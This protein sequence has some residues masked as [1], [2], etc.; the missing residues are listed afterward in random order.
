MGEPITKTLLADAIESAVRSVDGLPQ[1][2]KI[3]RVQALVLNEP[4]IAQ[5]TAPIPRLRSE[6]LQGV[7][8]IGA[9]QLLNAF[10][11]TKTLVVA[12]GWFGKTW[13]ADEVST[14]L[15]T[16]VSLC[17]AAYAWY[18]RETASRPLA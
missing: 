3:A 5:A 12:V 2:E 9:T 14:V 17:L 15:I 11:V 6:V 13:D 1:V 10:G 7:A 16:I 4:T 18:G 8:G